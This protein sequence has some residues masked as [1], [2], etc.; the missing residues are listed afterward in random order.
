MR[1]RL[2][3]FNDTH[4]ELALKI[5]EL[6]ESSDD[7]VEALVVNSRGAKN[8]CV[9]VADISSDT[10][11]FWWTGG[12]QQVAKCCNFGVILSSFSSSFEGSLLL[13]MRMTSLLILS[14]HIVTKINSS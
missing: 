1:F 5:S 2:L 11:I 13:Q 7:S 12:G 3:M 8:V 6:R 4:A 14:R 9:A 10:V